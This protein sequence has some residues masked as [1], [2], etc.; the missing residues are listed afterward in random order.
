MVMA[1]E[2][3]ALRIPNPFRLPNDPG[4][5]AVYIRPINPNNPGVVPDPAVPL[6][7]MEQATIDL[8]FTRC[9]NYY[10]SMVNIE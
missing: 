2:L 7:W 6:T 9:K 5:N 10:M 1:R 4:P 3:Y 8:M